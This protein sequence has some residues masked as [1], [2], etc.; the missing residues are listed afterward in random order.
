MR[1]VL[2][3]VGEKHRYIILIAVVFW[4]AFLNNFLC[5]A[6]E[7]TLKVI[8]TRETDAQN[9]PAEEAFFSHHPESV[10]EYTLYTEDQL[11][12][13][14]LS[15]TVEADI[16]ILPYGIL[17]NLAE[18]GYLNYLDDAAGIYEYPAQLLDLRRLFVRNNRVFALPTSIRQEFLAWNEG[19]G[20]RINLL[21]PGP[22]TWEWNEFAE[23]AEYFPCDSDD[24]G[25]ADTYL[26]YGESVSGYPYLNNVCLGMFQQYIASHFEFNTFQ[27]DYLNLFRKIVANKALLNISSMTGNGLYT[28]LERV[29]SDNP[30]EYMDRLMSDEK[31]NMLFLPMPSLANEDTAHTGY[32]WGCGVLKNAISPDL[33]ADFISAMISDDAL[34]C[35]VQM[36]YDQ[37][38]SLAAPH[39]EYQYSAY[40]QPEFA[41]RGDAPVFEI[42]PGR[43]FAMDDFLCSNE[44]FQQSQSFRAQL[45]VHTIPVGRD[46]Y[47]AAFAVIQEW[48]EGYIDDDGM[49][50]RVNYLLD[51][52]NGL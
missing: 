40:N 41:S 39:K 25:T 26:I 42:C 1:T 16:V 31:G 45:S 18:K 37:L 12:S 19:I 11:F 8:V 51:I 49:T 3:R 27:R 38:V 52:A 5:I 46:F 7:N 35:A 23:L 14:L 10:I 50:E 2:E 33:A 24:D 32:L 13:Q 9:W 44:A 17:N 29:A 20:N 4:T 43:D 47:D 22:E 15:Q 34:D 48:L 21:Y 28:I 36:R 6:E 30:I